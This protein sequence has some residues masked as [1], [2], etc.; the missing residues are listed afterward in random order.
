MKSN[1]VR[2]ALACLAFAL[3]TT[4]SFAEPGK[5]IDGTDVGLDHNP[6]GGRVATGVTDSEGN[7]RF[8][9]LAPG[10]YVL[11]VDGP[12][13]IKAMD[14]LAPARHS[15]GSSF[16]FGVGGLFGGGGSR[17]S[18]E[19]GGPTGG[20]HGT[21]GGGVG[22]GV[23]V[24]IG[25]QDSNGSSHPG[26]T[27]VPTTNIRLTLN[28]NITSRFVTMFSSETPYCR[29]TAGQGMRLGFKISENSSPMPRDRVYG[30]EVVLTATVYVA[31][32]SGG[33]W[34]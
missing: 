9:K 15:G 28:T 25:D 5:P 16:S 14:R 4:A 8:G 22:L 30:Q 20:S 11:V 26:E 12:S 23:N 34:K 3:S 33:V 13:L 2:A 27:A 24:P 6:G 21:S 1:F 10:E 7:I 32:A 18:S 29:D 19:K 17:H 31:G